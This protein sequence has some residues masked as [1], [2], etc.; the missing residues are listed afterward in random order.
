M[1]SPVVGDSLVAVL[2]TDNEAVAWRIS[3]GHEA[4]RTT[5]L[6]H[7][8]MGNPRIMGDIVIFGIKLTRLYVLTLSSGSMDYCT[9]VKGKGRGAGHASVAVAD[10]LVLLTYD[11]DISVLPAVRAGLWRFLTTRL[12]GTE[13]T[14]GQ[15][16]LVA[17]ELATG[18]ER[19]RVPL[20]GISG[21]TVQGHIA[22]TPGILDGFAYI[23]SP[24]NGH[25][26]A[27]RADSGRVLWFTPIKAVRG[28][29]LVTQGAVL[30]ATTDAALV[31]LDAATGKERCRQ[32]L[33]AASDRAGPT[34][35][36][37][38]ALLALRNGLV[39]A[40]PIDDMLHCHA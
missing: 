11:E 28:S 6:S 40:R 21:A 16:F 26:T 39:L 7:S 9:A 2:T 33:P 36:G 3:D 24:R 25:V 12:L 8:W 31:V 34:L 19:W 30:S 32:T 22:G 38:T 37:K 27:V 13:N 20:G 17:L 14:A 29:V 5:L 23:P 35:A 4:W 18:R 1:T 10:D 15:Q